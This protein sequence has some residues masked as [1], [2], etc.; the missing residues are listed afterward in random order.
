M[1]CGACRWASVLAAF[2]LHVPFASIH[3]VTTCENIHL[4]DLAWGTILVLCARAVPAP[5]RC[6]ALPLGA[7]LGQFCAGQMHHV[8]G[9]TTSLGLPFFSARACD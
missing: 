8:V 7:D 3:I 9:H 2:Y 4:H 6:T 5:R 1:L